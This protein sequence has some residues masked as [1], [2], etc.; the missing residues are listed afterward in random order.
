MQTH[1]P[2]LTLLTLRRP[3]DRYQQ[4]LSRRGLH[5]TALEVCKLLL[6]LNP[7]DPMGALF[8]LDYLAGGWESGMKYINVKCGTGCLRNTLLALTLLDPMGT[9][10]A[11]DYLT[12]G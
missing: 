11:V 8:A 12:G 9:L 6:A 1:I 2:Q 3:R 4:A 10:F 7:L 5:R